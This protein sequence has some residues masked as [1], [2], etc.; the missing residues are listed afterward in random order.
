M[1]TEALKQQIE[2]IYSK[3]DNFIKLINSLKKSY[4]I[5]FV[6]IGLTIIFFLIAGALIALP[7]FLENKIFKENYFKIISYVFSIIFVILLVSTF[8]FYNTKMG[9]SKIY[10]SLKSS[11]FDNEKTKKVYEYY[12][13]SIKLGDTDKEFLMDVNSTNNYFEYNYGSRLT[14]IKKSNRDLP[15]PNVIKF[16]FK[17][18]EV[19]FIIN[20]PIKYTHERTISTLISNKNNNNTDTKVY[21][22]STD[23]LFYKNTKFD[24]SYD[25]I[26]ITK[27]KHFD[28][29]FQTESVVFNKK[30]DINLPSNDIRAARFLSPKLIDK[31]STL[32]D[33]D[34]K[35]FGINKNFY[36]SKSRKTDYTNK[37]DFQIGALNYKKIKNFDSFK[38]QLINKVTRDFELLSRSFNYIEK[39]Y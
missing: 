27:G 4:F 18:N 3:D 19:H 39:I 22:I 23:D 20:H 11:Q 35:E 9:P 2:E 21:Y 6:L 7:F 37:I 1:D 12:F 14:L 10:K 26:K 25:G 38:K 33:K 17:D 15:K 32:N 28:K 16:T 13:K 31:M 30:Y 8:L 5:G 29:N 36:V 24:Q 34:F